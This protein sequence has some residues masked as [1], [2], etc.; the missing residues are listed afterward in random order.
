M[1]ALQTLAFIS[2]IAGFSC[3]LTSECSYYN[4]LDYLNL[5]SSNV[6]LETMR[7]VKN[8]TRSTFV[9]VDLFLLG[10]LESNEKSQT[11]TNEIRV[12]MSW[13]N[14][15]LTWNSSEFCGIE[16]LS[17]MTS[18]LWFPDVIIVEDVSDDGSMRMSPLVTVYSNGSVKADFQQRLT[19]ACRLNLFLFPFDLQTCYISFSSLNSDVDSITFGTISDERFLTQ[20][21]DTVMLTRGQW[22]L[23]HID[24]YST[25]QTIENKSYVSFRVLMLRKPM[26][27]VID[28][29]IPLFYFLIMD[30]A[31]F[32]ISEVKVEK[33][34]FKVTILLSISVLLL[35]LADILPSTEKHMPIISIYCMV[36]FTMVAVSV[37]ETMLVMFLMD[38]EGFSFY[39]KA[40]NCENA[41]T[42]VQLEPMEDSAETLKKGEGKPK[43]SDLPSDCDL[44]KL[45][46]DEVKAVQDKTG[47]QDEV[48]GKQESYRRLA[49][50]IDRV[51]FVL[52]LIAST[53]F[54]VLGYLK[55]IPQMI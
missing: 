23:K 9:Q 48:N 55:W 3:S 53:L 8:W 14:E 39:K 25:N 42:D 2:V 4:L 34:S 32:F 7:P 31:S 22:E 15:F 6:A 44:L 24:I 49:A 51:F 52:Y 17:I 33:L 16:K 29:I 1:A 36:I 5:T 43:R 41:K 11:F 10:I 21:S 20:V 12:H 13:T 35:L 38:F 50:I 28:F 18:M 40:E 26:L 37:L 19:F 45:I 30:L 27:Y 54:V 47:R 46:L